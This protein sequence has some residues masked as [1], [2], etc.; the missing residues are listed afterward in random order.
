MALTVKELAD[1]LGVDPGDIQVLTAQYPGDVP[2]WDET[3]V[4]APEV[5]DDLSRELSPYERQIPEF[6]LCQ[7]GW[8]DAPQWRDQDRR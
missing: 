4:L 5:R 8:R 3:V 2:L 1:E 7:R 6:Y